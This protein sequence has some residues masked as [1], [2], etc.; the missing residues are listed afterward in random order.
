M[1]DEYGIYDMCEAVF[2]KGICA[3]PEQH[4][5]RVYREGERRRR[6]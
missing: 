4:G 3:G 6:S 1:N 5:V 2:I